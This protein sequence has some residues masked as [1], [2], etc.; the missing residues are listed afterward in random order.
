[1]LS[2]TLFEQEKA[3]IKFNYIKAELLFSRCLLGGV[4]DDQVGF[5]VFKF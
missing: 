1:M 2:L 3:Y 5:I 4:Q